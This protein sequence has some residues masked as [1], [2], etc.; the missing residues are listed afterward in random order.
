M[1]PVRGSVF[2]HFWFVK[3]EKCTGDDKK[4]IPPQN[5]FRFRKEFL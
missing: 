3:G 5:V 1:Q 4:K 2:L